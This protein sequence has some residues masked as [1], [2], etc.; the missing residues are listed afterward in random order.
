MGDT[1]PKVEMWAI[2]EVMGHRRW[3]GHVTEEVIAGHSFVRV[4]VP[5]TGTLQA[6]TKLLGP[7]SIYAITPV[8]EEVAR[9]LVSSEGA[10]PV[11]AWRLL[12]A[13]DSSP[14]KPDDDLP[15]DDLPADCD[16]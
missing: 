3:V 7:Q 11:E 13:L 1:Q 10:R 14:P 6:F 15:A 4:D 16:F 12:P 8:S 9:R 5:A 2:V